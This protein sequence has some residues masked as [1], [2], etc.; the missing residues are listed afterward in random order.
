M[1]RA[2]RAEPPAL[3]EAVEPLGFLLGV[4]A[5]EG[6]GRYPTIEAFHY[7]EELHFSH[8]G[9][10]FVGYT[11]RTWDLGDDHL[12]HSETGY[13]RVTP[14]GR[15]ELVLAHPTGVVEVS[16]G[17]LH[18]SGSDRGSRG[19]LPGEV[20]PGPRHAGSLLREISLASRFVGLT[21]SAK[22]VTALARTIQVAGSEM[23]SSLDMA[24]M[25]HPF[26]P[27]LHSVLERVGP[28]ATR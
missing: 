11:Q 6:E 14:E 15:I 26:Q 16:E 5:G 9:K 18:T 21:S 13:W 8:N 19:D 12:L 28:G 1:T 4:W 27:H 22:S 17:T 7:G 23:R 24:A 25:G 20:A 3:H 2:A 10:A